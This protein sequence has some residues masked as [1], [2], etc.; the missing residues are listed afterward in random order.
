MPTSDAQKAFLL[1]QGA[2]VRSGLISVYSGGGFELGWL[3]ARRVL[4]EVGDVVAELHG[5]PAALEMMHR[6]IDAL[7]DPDRTRAM[8]MLS[9]SLQLEPVAVAPPAVTRMGDEYD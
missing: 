8:Q 6:T 1:T 2:S 7:M 5:R 4:W 9:E 3:S